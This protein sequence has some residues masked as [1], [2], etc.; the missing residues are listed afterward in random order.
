VLGRVLDPRA[1]DA[2]TGPRGAHAITIPPAWGRRG[3]EL[4]VALP[5]RLTCARC[6]GGGCDGC[7]RSGALRGPDDARARAVLVTLPAGLG[8]EVA[9]RVQRPFGA[10]GGVSQLILRVRIGTPT[11]GN[12]ERVGGVD[13]T[14]P[15]STSRRAASART[16][17]GSSTSTRDVGVLAVTFALLL[18]AAVLASLLR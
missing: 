12:V 16:A 5:K 7:G 10:D 8:D 18:L 2:S 11:S 6:D 17:R 3:A 14:S 15:P 9:L 13:V 1:L 4:R